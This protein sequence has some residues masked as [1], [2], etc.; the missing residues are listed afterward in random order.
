MGYIYLLILWW[1]IPFSFLRLRDLSHFAV[2]K[3][4][5]FATETYNSHFSDDTY[6]LTLRLRV[7]PRFCDSVTFL[8]LGS[9][10]L[11]GFMVERSFSFYSWGITFHL[12]LRQTLFHFAAE[13][14]PSHFATERPYR[15][16]AEIYL[17]VTKMRYAIS[18]MKYAIVEM[19]HRIIELNMRLLNE[20]CNYRNETYDYWMKIAIT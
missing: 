13:I 8:I 12:R 10:D 9:R 4:S 7:I 18:E 15:F 11:F 6:L 3:P 14:Y 2:E 19:K 1:A 16:L 17:R 5:Y 20:A